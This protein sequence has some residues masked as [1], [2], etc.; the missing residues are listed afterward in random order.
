MDGL[1]KLYYSLGQLAYVIAKA[2]GV[3]QQEEK[4]RYNKILIKFS[5]I[6]KKLVLRKKRVRI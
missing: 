4:Q 3:I 1:E 6:K 5:S 2:D